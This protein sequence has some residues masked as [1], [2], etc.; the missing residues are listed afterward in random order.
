MVILVLLLF[1]VI[2]L[3]IVSYN[4]DKR[5][6]FINLIGS[7]FEKNKTGYLKENV[8]CP[9]LP[10]GYKIRDRFP[11]DEYSKEKDVPWRGKAHV[12]MGHLENGGVVPDISFPSGKYAFFADIPKPASQD[13]NRLVFLGY[14]AR[15]MDWIQCY[16][17]QTKGSLIVTVF[18]IPPKDSDLKNTNLEGYGGI[19]GWVM[20]SLVPISRK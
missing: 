2:V 6:V 3:W 9:P 19:R 16:S 15:P 20:V 11:F 7:V 5:N 14:T 4:R 18:D 10:A 17:P 12:I 13:N 8:S 1:I